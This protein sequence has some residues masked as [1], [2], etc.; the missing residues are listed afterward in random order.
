V[1]LLVGNLI[2][3]AGAKGAVLVVGEVFVIVGIVGLIIAW[4]VGS[5]RPIGKSQSRNHQHPG[6]R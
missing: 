3:L 2:P 5:R 6:R 1:L 4:L